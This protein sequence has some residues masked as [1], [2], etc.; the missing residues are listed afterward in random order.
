MGL[1]W[2]DGA[3][4]SSFASRDKGLQFPEADDVSLDQREAVVLVSVKGELDEARQQHVLRLG[5][6]QEVDALKAAHGTHARRVAGERRE[7][8]PC[9][10]RVPM[11]VRA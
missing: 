10:L 3:D 2:S 4:G 5:E 11:R 7:V 1:C 9:I 8:Q 6:R